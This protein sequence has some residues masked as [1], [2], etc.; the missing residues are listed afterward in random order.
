MSI[1]KNLVVKLVVSLALL[2][3]KNCYQ[4][5]QILWKSIYMRTKCKGEVVAS[6]LGLV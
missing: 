2:K 5:V 1:C 3:K 4:F 6:Y